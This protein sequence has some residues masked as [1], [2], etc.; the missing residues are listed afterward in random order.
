MTDRFD[1]KTNVFN[2]NGR[3]NQIEFAIQAINNSSP[4]IAIKYS[5]G[6]AFLTY[7]I[8]ESKL[9]I[10]PEH[11]EKIHKID[12]HVFVIQSGVTADGN[13]LVQEMRKIGQ[14][15]FYI[16]ESPIPLEKLVDQMC[17]TKQLQTLQGGMRPYGCAFIYISHDFHDGFQIYTSDPSGNFAS[18][19]AIA[20]GQKGETIN[21]FLSEKYSESLSR[22]Q[23][24]DL[25]AKAVSE[26]NE[27]Q[28]PAEQKLVIGFMEHGDEVEMHYLSRSQKESLI[29][30]NAETL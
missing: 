11:G 10:Q 23:A 5:A 15:H 29:K 28:C 20:M 7:R 8:E 1:K 16:F 17:K 22:E 14:E 24:L 9:S 12:D 26:S 27:G 13:T 18:W 19:K 2:Q 4:V 6:I 30:R 25:L 21:T 3:I